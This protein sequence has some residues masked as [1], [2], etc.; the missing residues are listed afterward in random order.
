MAKVRGLAAEGVDPKVPVRVLYFGL[1]G[2]MHMLSQ[3]TGI[4]QHG[5]GDANL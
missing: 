2:S 5:V 3:V 1:L 4:G